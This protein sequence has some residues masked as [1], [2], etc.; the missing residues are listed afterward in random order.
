METLAESVKFARRRRGFAN[1]RDQS[2]SD[3]GLANQLRRRI[4]RSSSAQRHGDGQAE[5]N[6]NEKACTVHCLGWVVLILNSLCR[7]R[8]D[9]GW[10]TD[11]A[12]RRHVGVVGLGIAR[13]GQAIGDGLL[14][15][16]AEFREALRIPI[17]RPLSR[18]RN[19]YR[20]VMML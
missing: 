20:P 10:W 7:T 14:Q 17:S 1:L 6:P 3:S 19:G 18:F 16:S 15:Q 2:T 11:R 8:F 12:Y 13:T 4:S 9:V 5:S